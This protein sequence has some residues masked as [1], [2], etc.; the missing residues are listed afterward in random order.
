MYNLRSNS[1]FNN[2]E[3]MPKNKNVKNSRGNASNLSKMKSVD[4]MQDVIA[5]YA[6]GSSEKAAVKKKP[7][8][9]KSV[10]REV[11]KKGK[12]RTA[13]KERKPKRK[14]VRKSA[15]AKKKSVVSKKKVVAKKTKVAA[16]TIDHNKK[17]EPVPEINK[18]VAKKDKFIFESGDTKN[19]HKVTWYTKALTIVAIVALSLAGFSQGRAFELERKI[20][21]F[22]RGEG[23]PG[24]VDDRAVGRYL[25]GRREVSPSLLDK[26]IRFLE[27]VRDR[28][29]EVRDGDV[30]RGNAGEI[31]DSEPSVSIEIDGDVRVI[32]SNGIPD[33]GTG[34]FPNE[35]NP[36]EIR[37]QSYTFMV[38]VDP[39]L[40]VEATK[41]TNNMYFGVALNG[42]V[43]D[44]GTAEYYMGDMN[45][46]WNY[47]AMSGEVDL[48]LD[49]NNAH[50]QPNGAY[51]YHGKANGLDDSEGE[52]HSSLIGYAADGFPIYGKYG[53]ADSLDSTSGVVEYKS[54][55]ELKEGVR[56]GGPLGEYDGTFVEDYEYVGGELDE[57]NGMIGVTPEYPD[58]IYMYRLTDDFPFVPR[59]LR[60]FPDGSFRK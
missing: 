8:K 2:I 40:N 12:P 25:D 41:V 52:V 23:G 7:T 27:K 49:E 16:A 44:P 60:G 58:G 26:L 9:T 6:G 28:R 37:P 46:G 5:K 21:L 1:D 39:K 42:V 13:L 15:P 34:E 47:E 59:C 30:M 36:N 45:S 35:G 33:H 51:H 43:F 32:K 57:C 48:G 56:D 19:L 17:P 4:E 54:G 55:Y 18:T 38:P 20:A 22:D 14:V 29:V 24:M 3:N 11:V 53:Y 31:L 10:K 50:V